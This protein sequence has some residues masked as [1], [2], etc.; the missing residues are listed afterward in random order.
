M[1]HALTGQIRGASRSVCRNLKEAWAKRRY[2]THFSGKLT[3]CD[4]ENDE[5][6]KSWILPRTVVVSTN[7][8][9]LSLW[10]NAPRLA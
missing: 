1:S 3:D 5:T 10:R 9:I 8:S 4:G 2:E 6:D 7:K